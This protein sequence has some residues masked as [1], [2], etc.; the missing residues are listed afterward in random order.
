MIRTFTKTRERKFC[1]C[2]FPSTVDSVFFW[3]YSEPQFFENLNPLNGFKDDNDFS[4]FHYH[5][6]QKLEPKDGEPYQGASWKPFL[7]WI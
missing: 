6:S 2:C 3:I 4:E 5:L 1:S 7:N